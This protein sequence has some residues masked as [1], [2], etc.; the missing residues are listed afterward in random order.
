MRNN[1]KNKNWVVISEELDQTKSLI[2]TKTPVNDEHDQSF[3]ELARQLIKRKENMGFF[4]APDA[5]G[6]ITGWCGD[7]MQIHLMLD[8]IIIKDARFLTDGC[9]ATIACG[10]MITKLVQSKTLD[11]AMKISPDDLLTE[12]VSIPDD[13]EHCLSLAVSTLRMAIKN[14]QEIKDQQN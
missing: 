13:H 5:C 6:K 14:A 11:Q 4:P 1:S 9:G 7:T 12:L 2:K 10:S 8:G 3:S